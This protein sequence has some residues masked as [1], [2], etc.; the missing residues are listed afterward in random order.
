L[1]LAFNISQTEI[2][3]VE[4]YQV[5]DLADKKATKLRLAMQDFIQ[6]K[7]ERF[8]QSERELAASNLR[9]VVFFIISKRPTKSWVTL[10]LFRLMMNDSLCFSRAGFP[11]TISC[12]TFVLQQRIISFR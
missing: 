8:G 11:F 7:R 4:R 5:D 9:L 2:R 3:D 1:L 12:I 10:V 6:L